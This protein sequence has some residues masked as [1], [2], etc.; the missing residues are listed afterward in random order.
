MKNKEKTAVS[1]GSDTFNSPL[2]ERLILS[3]A[4]QKVKTIVPQL[5][6]CLKFE[7]V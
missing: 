7:A 4:F 3:V 6:K 1:Q 5:S 2:Q